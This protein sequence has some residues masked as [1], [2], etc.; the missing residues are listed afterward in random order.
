[1]DIL[2][3]KPGCFRCPRCLSDYDTRDTHIT[4]LERELAATR[5]KHAEAVIGRDRLAARRDEYR[6][7]AVRIEREN[8]RLRRAL[9]WIAQEPYK[10]ADQLRA[11]AREALAATGADAQ[12]RIKRDSYASARNESV[13]DG[14]AASP[15]REERK[16]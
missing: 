6:D 5:V 8:Q 2:V 4:E 7:A 10:Y 14:D 15:E 16:P 3:G 13:T 1:M 12:E 9:E 11:M